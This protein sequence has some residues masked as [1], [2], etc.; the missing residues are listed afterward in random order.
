MYKN[1]I[2]EKILLTSFVILVIVSTIL[3]Y[4]LIDFHNDYVCSTTTNIEWIE[5]HKCLKYYNINDKK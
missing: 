1:K 2:K 4:I 3:V 5:S